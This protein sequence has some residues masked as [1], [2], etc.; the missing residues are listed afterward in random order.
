MKNYSNWSSAGKWLFGLLT[1]GVGNIILKSIDNVSNAVTEMRN[2]RQQSE[3]DLE[4]ALTNTDIVS[5]IGDAFNSTSDSPYLSYRSN[6][7]MP[8]FNSD[9]DNPW[10]SWLNSKTGAGLTNNE[11]IK[12]M[13]QTWERQQ[14][15]NFNH[16]EAVDARQYEMYMA[17]NKYQMET[18]S[19]AAA[20]VNPAMVYG[21]GSLVPTAATGA[22]GSVSPQSAPS[23]PTTGSLSG[24]IDVLATIMR[25]PLEMKSINADISKSKADA[26][27]SQKE[28][29]AAIMNA[30]SNKQNAES[31]AR[32]ASTNE[33]LAT[34]QEMRQQVDADLAAS[35]IKVNDEQADKIAKEA[36]Y[37]ETQ[38]QQLDDYL[39]LEKL[40]VSAQEKQALA[41]LQSSLAAVRN[42][43]VNENLSNFQK[44]V[45]QAQ[46]Y[47]TWA[48][49]DGKQIVNKYLDDKQQLEIRQMNATRKLTD[50]ETVKTYVNCGTDIAGAVSKFVG[51]GA[52]RSAG[53]EIVR[54]NDAKDLIGALN[55]A[56]AARS[57]T[58]AGA[59]YN[60]QN[61]LK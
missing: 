50:A 24:L 43:A 6:N 4:N 5:D 23:A 35:N 8:N 60:M 3:R 7:S 19:M 2:D 15:E 20:G 47:T 1:G 28:G 27:R 13:Y 41:A 10:A 56:S 37:I 33:R 53:Q 29:D 51:I 57:M 14:A 48:E 11:R 30:E 21:G 55:G 40:K 9:D 58:G 49:G 34:V 44:S 25:L 16:N 38:T 61:L 26:I 52:L 17:Q 18:Q 36:S 12:M 45:L 39:D 32:N 22:T 59:A 42:A 46:A 31:N 54:S